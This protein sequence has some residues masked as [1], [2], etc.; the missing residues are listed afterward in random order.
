MARRLG[1]NQLIFGNNKTQK[2]P[3]FGRG[4]SLS[5]CSKMYFSKP[6]LIAIFAASAFV[7]QPSLNDAAS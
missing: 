6:L 1:L 4:F 2:N 3:G 5:T 7:S